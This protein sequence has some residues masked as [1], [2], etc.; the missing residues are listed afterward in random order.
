MGRVTSTTLPD[1]TSVMSAH[2]PTGLTATNGGSRAYPVGYG[3]DAQG[4][5]M[6]MTNWGQAGPEVTTW[7]YDANRGWLNSR[8]YADT[9]GPSYTYTAAGRLAGRLWA[10]GTSTTNSQNAAGDVLSVRYSDSTPGMTNGYDR[11][12]R[13]TTI[14]NGATVTTR[15]LN[16]VGE[17]LQETN[18]GG[19]LSHLSVSNVYDGV[20]RRTN[21]SVLSNTTVLAR[22]TNSFD[23]ASRLQTVSDG[24]NWVQDKIVTFLIL[25]L[26][27]A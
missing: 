4:R 15:A 11:R 19:V 6:K 13:L 20:L 7:N 24:V 2:Y 26:F 25:P 8:K 27:F 18:A 16:D 22:T 21:M 14:T 1:G 5:M 3:Y 9:N 12:G 17:L 10:R 23:G